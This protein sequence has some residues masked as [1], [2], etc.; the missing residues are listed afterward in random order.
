MSHLRRLT[1]N[2]L[3]NPPKYVT[4]G[5]QYETVMGSVSYG[6]SNN[7]SDMDIYGFCIP[8]K[9]M[10][11]PHI[12]GEISG[13]GRQTQRFE[14]FQQHHIKE[15][16]KEYDFSIYSII[17]YFQLC[18]DCN[19]NMIDSLFTPRRCVTYTSRIGEMVRE[20]RKLFL[21]KGSWFKFKGYSFSQMHKMRIKNPKPESKRYE[22]V[23]THGYDLK[24]AYHVVRLLLEIEQILVEHDLDLE[25]N[26]EQLKSIRR[27]EW[28]LE[29]IENYF[30]SKEREL[31]SL[32]TSSKLQHSPDEGKIKQLLINCLEEYF[33]S[34]GN[35]LILPNSTRLILDDLQTII[36]KY[37]VPEQDK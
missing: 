21:H 19:P 36:N 15:N 10:I 14:Q 2:N 27:G 35:C 18:M 32:Y 6:V 8:T 12:K 30:S 4:E 24:F 31:E 1:K 23:L 33:G 11:F 16:D 13:F 34:L 17:K 22:S 28:E 37:N 25:R 26:R 3:I 9:E 5:L 29:E 7:E 20:N